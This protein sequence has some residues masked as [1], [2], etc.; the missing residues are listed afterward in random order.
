MIYSLTA[1]FISA[2]SERIVTIKTPAAAAAYDINISRGS[3]DECGSWVRYTLGERTRRV[4]IVSNRKVY[5]LYGE[6][7]SRS[8]TAAGFEVA[9]HL[10]ADGER[11]KTLPTVER[12]L[13]TFS[14]GGITRTDAVVALGGGIVGDVAGFAAAVY[15]R[16]IRFLQIPTTLLAMIDSSVGGKTGVN[17]AFGKNLIGAF[18]QP[19]GVLIDPAVLATLP[20]RE[21]TAGFCE[22]VKHGAI[23]GVEL[24]DQVTA[25]LELLQQKITGLAE[26]GIEAMIAE[27]VA[28]KA[29]IVAG[30][31]H[32]DPE[33]VDHRSRKILNFGHTFGHALEK[34]TDYRYLKHGE[35]V[36]YGI[37]FAA[38]L[39][40][41]LELLSQDEV[42]LLNDVVHRC[43][44]LPAI[45][46]INASSL[47]ETFLFDKKVVNNSLQWILLKGIGEPVIVSDDHITRAAVIETIEKTLRR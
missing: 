12:T 22:A 3:L 47:F 26:S 43:G 21:L 4:A 44:K 18:H 2:M 8:L 42:N 14:G 11:F 45:G 27:Q 33:R 34:V 23:G 7:V 31:E 46:H 13:A 10:I 15:L 9:V 19:S 38:E 36:G 25:T 39:S 30:D 24:L 6:A 32:E 40:K 41:K 1:F 35:A 17:S 37:I 29:R 20:R 16:G 28:F 5:S